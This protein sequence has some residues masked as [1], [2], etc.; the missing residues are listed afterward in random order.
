ML[1]VS[2]QATKRRKKYFQE[3]PSYHRSALASGHNSLNIRYSS[4][5]PQSLQL[6]RILHRTNPL[7]SKSEQWML[8]SETC[9]SVDC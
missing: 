8:L 5:I 3:A 2:T 1:C 9:W 4:K 6:N 7:I